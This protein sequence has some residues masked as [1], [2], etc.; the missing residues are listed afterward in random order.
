MVNNK[1]RR[2]EATALSSTQ[3]VDIFKSYTGENVKIV[4]TNDMRN[5][6]KLSEILNEESPYVILFDPVNSATSGH[7]QALFLQDNKYYFFDSYGHSYTKLY[8]KVNKAY[9]MNAFN[10]SDKIGKLL[11]YSGKDTIQNLYPYQSSRKDDDTCGRHSVVC[12]IYLVKNIRKGKLFDFNV[13]YDDL[14][15]F[16]NSNKLKTYDEAVVKITNRVIDV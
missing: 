12:L 10:N 2:D 5:I 11:Y 7:Y 13:Y 15:I 8:N 3:V 9:G 16:K 1:E 14:T 4:Q 6:N